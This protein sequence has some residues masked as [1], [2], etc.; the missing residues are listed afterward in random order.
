[1]KERGIG[2]P[3]TYATIISKLLD[4]RYVISVKNKLIATK[5]GMNVYEYLRSKFEKYVSEELTRELEKKMDLI[6][7]NKVDY[8]DVLKEIYEESIAIKNSE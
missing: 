6:E 4:R 1:M 2:R 3:S 5:K 7:E 8:T